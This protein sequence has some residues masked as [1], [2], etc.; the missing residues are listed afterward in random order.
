MKDFDEQEVGGRGVFLRAD[1]NVPLDG[2]RITDDGRV[3]ASLPT[4]TKLAE[5][6]ARVIVGAHLGRPKGDGY[7]ERAAGGPS[8]EPVAEQ[9]AADAG[10]DER[11]NHQQ[12]GSEECAADRSQTPDNDDE[13]DLERA[14]KVESRRLDRAQVGE[15]PERS[16]HAD[17]E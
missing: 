15:G 5:R 1:L 7:A 6:G 2:T 13:D 14:I 8:L 17:N 10:E 12:C 3:R 4:I 9:K 11:K 16:R